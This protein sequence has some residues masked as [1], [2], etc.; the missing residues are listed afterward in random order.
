MTDTWNDADEVL[1]ARPRH[2]SEVPT[3]PA[4]PPLREDQVRVVLG[5]YRREQAKLASLQAQLREM[6]INPENA[7]TPGIPSEPTEES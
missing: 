6:G 1:Q 3:V 7:W 5:H 2:P 4:P